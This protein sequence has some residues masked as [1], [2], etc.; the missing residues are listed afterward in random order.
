MPEAKPPAAGAGLLFL[1]EEEMRL[2]QDLLFFAMRDL[3]AAADQALASS[4]LGRA[5]HRAL[6]FIAAQPGLTVGD[7]LALLG[8]TKQSL[9]RVLTALVAQGLVRQAEGR[10]DRRQRQLFLTE[11]GAALEQSLFDCQRARLNAAY[12]EAGGAA[13]E[14]FK[15]VLRGIMG[16]PARGFVDQAR[17]STSAAGFGT[18]PAG[19]SPPQPQPGRGR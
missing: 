14:G 19:Q 12:R 5:H 8:I 4:G 17:K 3:G 2:A 18:Q 16:A 9:S 1:R 6:H 11:A 10:N 7:L 15:R 13:V